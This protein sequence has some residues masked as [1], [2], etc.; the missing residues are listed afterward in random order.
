MKHIGEIGCGALCTACGG[1][2]LVCPVGAVTMQENP[3]GF[4]VARVDETVC[5]NCGLCRK[6]CKL[7]GV[8][9]TLQSQEEYDTDV[10]EGYL[11]IF[12]HFCP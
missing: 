5:V 7:Q 3:A 4:M 6:V 1:C 11:P 2:A 8:S 12:E 9:W 10:K